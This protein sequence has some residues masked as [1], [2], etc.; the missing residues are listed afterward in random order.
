MNGLEHSNG[1]PSFRERFGNK[2]TVWGEKVKN[3]PDSTPAEEKR[4]ELA[5]DYIFYKS[6]DAMQEYFAI[7]QALGTPDKLKDFFRNRLAVAIADKVA[8]TES[9]PEYDN[10]TVIIKEDKRSLWRTSSSSVHP[11]R[12]E[13]TDMGTMTNLKAE[14]FKASA[15][16]VRIIMDPS[17]HHD[18]QIILFSYLRDTKDSDLKILRGETDEKEVNRFRE[19]FAEDNRIW[20]YKKRIAENYLIW[21]KEQELKVRY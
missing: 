9:Y 3:T 7:E 15:D 1:K 21:K 18:Y 10:T 14:L 2:I 6:A 13:L 20:W 4:E 19:L 16:A 12:T 17:F 5:I 8:N 11:F